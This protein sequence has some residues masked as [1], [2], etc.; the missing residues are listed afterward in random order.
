MSVP[1]HEKVLVVNKKWQAIDETTVSQALC[2]MCAGKACG[3]DTE[4][5]RPVTWA[6]WLTLAI[7]IGDRQIQTMRGPVRVPTVVGKF[8]FDK[9]PKRKPKMDNQGIAA[10]DHRI[11]QVTGELALD[12]NVDH[13]IPISRGGARKSWTNM[14][15]M[16]KNL[17]SQKGNRTLQEMGWKLIQQPVKPEDM[18]AFRYITPKHPDWLMFLPKKK[19]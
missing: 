16:K 10:R 9:M 5:M 8:S 12:G 1:L 18:E 7:R 13:L 6:E 15:W 11:C 2:D 14:V 19:A 4:S 17:N 3:F